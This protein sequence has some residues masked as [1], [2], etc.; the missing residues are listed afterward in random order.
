MWQPDLSASADWLSARDKAA[1]KRL[2][3]WPT[4][5]WVCEAT[6]RYLTSAEPLPARP[7]VAD[8]ACGDGRWLL[9]AAR[10]VPDARLIGID[11]DPLAIEAARATLSRAGV[12]AELRCADGLA[13]GALPDCD[14]IV[15]N[16][17]FVRPQHLER[18]SAK[19][20]WS[21]FRAATDKCDLSVCFL[22]LSL[23][24][25][26]L[27]AL[28]LPASLLSMR[29]YAKARE[30][31]LSRG[32]GAVLTLPPN[33]FG[34]SIDAVLVISSSSDAR[35]A[36]VLDP[37][38][39]SLSGRLSESALAWSV[40]GELPELPGEPLS[41]YA[42]VH[43]GVVCGD[44]DRY[45]HTGRRAAADEPTCR[46]RDVGRFTIADRGELLRYL[47]EEMLARKPY[48][49][50]KS[51]GLFDVPEK[52]VLAGASGS[53]IRAA[54][55]DQRR[56][57]LDSCY[58][59]RERQGGPDTYGLL[60][61]LLSGPVGQWYGRRFRAVRVKGSEIEKIPLPAPPWTEIAEAARARDEIA[62]EEAVRRAYRLD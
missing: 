26:P 55:D 45:V 46:G 43:M 15:G 9:A 60:G 33:I 1:R 32:V 58:V 27:S 7:L 40:D 13:E 61:L 4:P 14:L 30:L 20:L 51:R 37:Q 42:T 10:Q 2:G 36:G 17:P 25:A 21:R 28:V 35:A 23:S 24:R 48:V 29:S 19:A 8:P 3:Q 56:F 59:L 18:A 54:V 39:L 6:L 34:A 16:P 52:V 38:G 12:D 11:I 47:P 62:L 5:Y 57:P 22:E 41:R 50:P 44:Y 53:E 31:L 49:A